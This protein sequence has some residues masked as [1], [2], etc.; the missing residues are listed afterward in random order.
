[1][2]LQFEMACLRTESPACSRIR[3][4]SYGS[5]PGLAWPSYDRGRSRHRKKSQ[6]HCAKRFWNFG[7][8]SGG[9]WIAT[10]NHVLAVSRNKL[11]GRKLDSSDVVSMG[12]RMAFLDRRCKAAA[13]G[14]C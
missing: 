2:S 8:K 11:L 6:H 14:V 3:L 4:A 7:D 5:V 13:L 9:L 10:A 12:K 1:M